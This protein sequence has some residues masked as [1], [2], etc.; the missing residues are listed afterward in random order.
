VFNPWGTKSNGYAPGTNN[1]IYGLFPANAAFLSQNFAMQSL[2]TGVAPGEDPAGPAVVVTGVADLD[3][4]KPRKMAVVHDN[5]TNG[6]TDYHKR[7][8][9][10]AATGGGS[11][12]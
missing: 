8:D 4:P 11:T 6:G 7:P 12:P 9:V 10:V 1:T 3:G 2:G 5:G